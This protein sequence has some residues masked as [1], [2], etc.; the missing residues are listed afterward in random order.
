MQYEQSFQ[1]TNVLCG[2][3]SFANKW[4]ACQIFY[5]IHYN[6]SQEIT[7]ITIPMKQS[8]PQINCYQNMVKYVSDESKS[9]GIKFCCIFLRT[10]MQQKRLIFCSKFP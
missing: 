1:L 3:H 2:C 9:L 7:C 4:L 10:D 8:S 6:H 5:T